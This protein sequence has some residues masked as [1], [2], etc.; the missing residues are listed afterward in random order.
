MQDLKEKSMAKLENN[1][2]LRYGIGVQNYF[3]MQLTML[4][5]FAIICLF[6]IPQ[7]IVYAVEG[8][9]GT[10]FSTEIPLLSLT[11]QIS[12]GNMGYSST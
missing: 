11:T 12:F 1:P 10:R 9:I 5:L 3:N 4:K 7:M 6:T 8:G 2:F